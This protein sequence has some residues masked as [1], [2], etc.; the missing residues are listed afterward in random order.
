MNA[1]KIIVRGVKRS[2][3]DAASTDTL[4]LIDSFDLSGA[5]RGAG[6][7]HQVP[8]TP[9]TV[10]ELRFEDDVTWYCSRSSM[11]ELFPGLHVENR[12]GEQVVELPY[13]LDDPDQERGGRGLLLRVVTFFTKKKVVDKAVKELASKLELSVLDMNPGLYRLDNNFELHATTPKSSA[14]PY[15]LFIHGTASSTQKSFGGLL[16]TDPWAY[17]QNTYGNRVLA[18]QHESLTK[19]PLDNVLA[20]VEDLPD[21]CTLHIITQSRG[22]MV[23]ETLSRF[24]NSDQGNAGF[25]KDEIKLLRKAGRKKDVTNITAIQNIVSAKRI[26]IGKFIRVACPGAG[27]TL[28]SKRLDLVLNMIF[29]LIGVATGQA[30][31]PVFI[32]FKSLIGAVIDC[33]NDTDV[34]PGL[35]AMNRKSPFV[36]ALNIADSPVKIDNSLILIAG[37]CKLKLDKKALLVIASKIFFLHRNDLIVDTESMY[38]RT[39]R[40]GRVQFFFNEGTDI[41]HF[42]YFRNPLT[43]K[44]LEN[45]LKTP[46]GDPIEDFIEL[47]GDELPA[48]QYRGI[49]GI[50]HGEVFQDK[51][52]GDRPI[53]VVLPGIMGSN[54]AKD[55]DLVWIRYLKFLTGGLKNLSIDTGD[56]EAA[57]LVKTSY[58]KLVRH[59][60]STYDV[61]TYPYDWR[62]Q[63]AT[64]AREFKRKIDE[65][66]KYN[67]PI[68]IVAHSMGGVMFRDF[69]LNHPDTWQ[70]LNSSKDFKLVFLGAPLGGSFR[71]PAVLFGED[72]VID[73]LNKIDRVHSEE[74]LLGIFSKLPGILSLLPI[75]RVHDF[76]KPA[77]WEA[78]RTAHGNDEWPI[79]D[80][81][82][83]TVFGKY[84]DNILANSDDI[85]FTNISYIAGQ[86]DATVCGYV[87]EETSEGKQL[88]FESTAEGDASVTWDTGIPAKMIAAN[89]VYYCNVTHGALANE[90]KL[91]PGITDLLTLGV[92]NLLSRSRP[93]VPQDRK[94]FRSPMLQD[95]DITDAGVERT[96]LGIGDG[97]KATEPVP[98]V[99]VTVAK[100]D[101]KFAS[102]PV[103]AGHFKNDGV[104]YA[105]AAIDKYLDG[106]LTRRHRL[107]IYPGDVGTSEF[108]DGTDNFP[109]VVIVGLGDPGT[110][111]S[112]QLMQTVEQG[113]SKYLLLLN[114]KDP[115]MSLRSGVKPAISALAIASGYGGITVENSVRAIIQGVCKA[116]ARIRKVFA[117]EAKLIHR[118]DF[119]EQYEDRALACMQAVNKVAAERS[120]DAFIIPGSRNIFTHPGYRERLPVDGTQGWWTRITVKLEDTKEVYIREEDKADASIKPIVIKELTYS[121]STGGAREDVQ[122][123][124]A[125]TRNIDAMVREISMK[126]KWNDAQATALFNL[127]I[128]NDFK[129]RLKRQTNI[130]WIVDMD[131]A[132]YPWELLK[133]A[134]QTAKPL[135]I[136]A[137]MIR[138]L[139]T[140]NYNKHIVPVN[141]NKVLV[142][143]D[144]VLE[145][146]LPQLP[147]ARKEGELVRNLLTAA[148]YDTDDSE[149]GT[150]HGQIMTRMFSGE[151]KIV[152]LAGHGVYDKN[153]PR[154]SGMVTGKGS[155]LSGCDISQM[156]PIPE[157]VIVNC[158]HLGRVESIEEKFYQDR[159]RIA[160]NVGVQLI[161]NGV[162]AVIAAG[163]E[164]NDSA[165]LEF[166]RV[167]YKAMFEGYAFGDAI[168]MARKTVYEK[169]GA[170][171][172]WGAYQC[173]GDPYYRLSSVT[174]RAAPPRYDFVVPEEAEVELCNVLNDLE[175]S[176]LPVADF[177]VKLDAISQAVDR[178]GVRTPA[179][180]E[181]EALIYAD[182]YDN[183]RAMERFG[184]LLKEETAAFSLS[185]VEDYCQVQSI[186]LVQESQ[187]RPPEDL[188]KAQLKAFLNRRTRDLTRR[189]DKLT[190]DVQSLMKVSET[191]ERCLMLGHIF[192]R[193]A[194]L[195]SGRDQKTGFYAQAAYYYNRASLFK[196]S[197]YTAFAIA[198]W[199]EVEAI[200][201]AIR[202]HRWGAT[203]RTAKGS[204]DMPASLRAASDMLE[205]AKVNAINRNGAVTDYWNLLAPVSMSLAAWF[206]S[207]ARNGTTIASLLADYKK[208]WTKAGSP[209]KKRSELEHLDVLV[210]LLSLSNKREARGMEEKVK[211]LRVGLEK[212]MG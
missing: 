131:T 120:D 203:V 141:N 106:E 21:D 63:L 25:S 177:Q 195:T 210:D 26:R 79:P 50:E 196:N 51:V 52:N 122:R 152:H 185:S 154:G 97:A 157:L 147:G 15:L 198:Y 167:F 64:R 95:F 83:L 175:I 184:T 156:T 108:V 164:V 187:K 137:G 128:P 168:F 162:R 204:F 7:E 174:R 200:L 2:R 44:A 155:T 94:L 56:I 19:S 207:S 170:Y 189:M 172:T 161:N 148:G 46:N 75:S 180:T 103:I 57:S 169:F 69:I 10:M 134:V 126:H 14:D 39:E 42:K 209:A 54:L 89:S 24:C 143:A 166:T 104:L 6:D 87:I 206:L 146:Y 38:A 163:W 149:I 109:G 202:K 160:A 186:F 101:L 121:I 28:A 199:L 153:N 176:S 3:A 12:S 1:D 13:V 119:I 116:N 142:V 70:K 115:S 33:K 85:D 40:T 110:L 58:R 179:V 27:T 16:G 76:S 193:R 205:K 135:S 192:E 151:Y 194:L 158:C 32:A 74:E 59:F 88:V 82:D 65:L 20:L 99:S 31:N 80:P 29:N 107:G 114:S 138:Q 178:A 190:R 48:A 55:G 173:Y 133:D 41:D 45:A 139:A 113:V 212:G 93:S 73:K 78:M 71:I 90:P 47:V 92:T 53:L 100:G 17:I 72:S 144:P 211:E 68:K 36:K 182:L 140:S 188:T 197:S 49:F 132:G 136:N 34:L 201:T 81:A 67:Q 181:K 86:D 98:V 111:T 35:E 43:L 66:L 127:L 124:Q 112:Y 171:N 62:L 130:N 96:L 105:E 77:T 11:D 183:A 91:F 4:E 5:A 8:I 30:A 150:T 18:F 60:S 145:G 165:A 208:V 118:V 102:S 61:V 37:N 191:A 129:E 123:V 9:E 159:F 23:G 84:R 125:S 22:G 117:N